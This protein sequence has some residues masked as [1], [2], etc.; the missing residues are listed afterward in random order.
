MCD[1]LCCLRQLLRRALSPT[2]VFCILR[3]AFCAGGCC[4]VLVATPP[5]ATVV[6]ARS[7][8]V[9]CRKLPNGGIIAGRMGGQGQVDPQGRPLGNPGPLPNRVCVPCAPFISVLFP[10]PN[11][12]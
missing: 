3:S 12:H 1:S 9:V 4:S 7:G 11:L 2:A 10:S 6:A 8:N 5:K